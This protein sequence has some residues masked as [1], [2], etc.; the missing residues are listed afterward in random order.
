MAEYGEEREEEQY[1]VDQGAFQYD[2]EVVQ[3]IMVEPDANAVE[4]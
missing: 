3:E 1:V 4:E 2:G